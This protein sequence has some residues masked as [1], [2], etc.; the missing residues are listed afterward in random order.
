MSYKLLLKNGGDRKKMAVGYLGI[1]SGY[2]L[3]R[4][5]QKIKRQLC[6]VS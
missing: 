1:K 4:E 2:D 5:C 6:G 3:F